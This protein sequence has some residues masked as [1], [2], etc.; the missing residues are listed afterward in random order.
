MARG[1]ASASPQGP[2]R[3]ITCKLTV[4]RSRRSLLI[5]W[6]SCIVLSGCQ[7]ENTNERGPTP[8]D[9][10]SPTSQPETTCSKYNVTFEG[11]ADKFVVTP[12]DNSVDTHVFT[13][14][15]QNS[16]EV[17]VIPSNWRIERKGNGETV[18]SGEGNSGGR[19]IL[20]GDTHQWSLSLEP[21]P[22]PFTEQTTFIVSDLEQGDYV[23]IVSYSLGSRGQVSHRASFTIVNHSN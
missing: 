5:Y 12:D 3:V 1:L 14:H 15:N 23:F 13:L 11:E 4:P 16:C 9:T 22:T 6:S 18:T 8:T 19:T 2:Y 10:R 7:S 17:T 20:A 21:H